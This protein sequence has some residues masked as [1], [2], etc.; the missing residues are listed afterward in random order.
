MHN[1]LKKNV[2]S[3]LCLLVLLA[4]SLSKES[5]ADKQSAPL[6]PINKNV[7]THCDNALEWYDDNPQ[8]KGEFTR[9]LDYCKKYAIDPSSK[10]FK[11]NPILSDF[12]SINGVNTR[13]RDQVHQ[14]ID[15]IGP[16]QQPV[17]A[18]ANGIVL[19]TTVEDCWG[20]TVVVDHGE[21]FDGKNFIVIYGHVGE[22]TVKENEIVKRGD[23][24]AKLPDKVKYRCMARVRHL[25][26]QI[27]Q[28][29]CKKEEKDNWGCKYFIKDYYSSLN[30]HNYW[31]DGPNK[32]TCYD[33]TRKY[34]KGTITYPFP[35][36]KKN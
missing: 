9:V 28:R 3:K 22:F 26:L 34:K 20:S 27:G 8:L 1:V 11:I 14:G 6:E 19:E 16:K 23:L 36:S 33:K 5:L 32:V 21:S 35:C 12:A 10:D 17:I 25:H 2:I 29:Y 24:I 18:I 30:P 7:E 15:I 4:F 31:A 13:P